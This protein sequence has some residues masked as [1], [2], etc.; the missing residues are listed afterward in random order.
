VPKVFNLHGDD[1]DRAEDRPGWRSKDAW[2]GVRIGAELIGGSLYELDPGDRLYPYHTHHANEEWL[3]VVRG[4]PTLRTPE[5]ET[6]L[7]EGDVVAFPRGESG[8]HQVRNGTEQPIRVL[9]LSTL[10]LPELVE[11]ADSGKLGARNAKGERIVLA[12]PGDR[13]DYWD[14]E[15]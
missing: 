7:S 1:W 8:L 5:G 14:G 3:V 11:Y 13:L 10:I 12:R 2:V 6:E 15:D 9:M 4:R